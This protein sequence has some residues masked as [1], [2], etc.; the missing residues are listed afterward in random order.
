[1][2]EKLKKLPGMKRSKRL[3][4]STQ[5]WL[6]KRETD[7][8]IG[9]KHGTWYGEDQELGLNGQPKREI[10]RET[11]M[12]NLNEITRIESA[13]LSGVNSEPPDLSKIDESE[14]IGDEAEA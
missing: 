4:R 7:L 10:L 5:Y 9:F 14:A 12:E 13:Y 1:M 2:I 6:R 3:Y 11:V 8:L